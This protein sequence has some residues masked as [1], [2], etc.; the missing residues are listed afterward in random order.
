MCGR[1]CDVCGGKRIAAYE[2]TSA[3]DSTYR[4]AMCFACWKNLSVNEKTDKKLSGH[5]VMW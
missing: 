1:D 5:V 2:I 3:M 4:K